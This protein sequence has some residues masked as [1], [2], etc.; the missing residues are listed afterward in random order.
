MSDTR[1]VV[2]GI[3]VSA[4]LVD[5]EIVKQRKL[6]LQLKSPADLAKILGPGAFDES[7]ASTPLNKLPARIAPETET[8]HYDAPVGASRRRGEH[9]DE[10]EPLAHA[11]HEATAHFLVTPELFREI[12]SVTALAAHLKVS[13]MTV[14]R[15]TKNRE[16]LRRV[17]RLAGEEVMLAATIARRE[18]PEITEKM[19]LK[20]KGGDVR[21]AKV[22]LDIAVDLESRSLTNS[23]HISPLTINEAIMLTENSGV[24]PSWKTMED[25]RK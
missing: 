8:I 18:L 14:H 6:E 1:V 3:T 13:R 25:E 17:K 7:N 12:K 23:G 5:C 24:A 11:G 15:W 16:V 19:I 9:D 20:A 22:V 21:A 4:F 10:G 2:S